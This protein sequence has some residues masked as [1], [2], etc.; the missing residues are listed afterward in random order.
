MAAQI[1]IQD[2]VIELGEEINYNFQVGDL[3]EIS[4]SKSTYTSS[5]KIPRLS[6]FERLFNGLGIAADRSRHPYQIND[7]YLLD[8][9]VPIMKG[10]LVFMRTDE[11][12][13]NVTAISGAFDFFTEIGE[14]KFSDIDISEIVHEKTLDTVYNNIA[15]LFPSNFT[16]AFG[17][18][19]GISHYTDNG[20]PITVNIDA[21][22][23][24]VRAK[25]L[26]NKIFAAFPRFT[27]SGDFYNSTDFGG[28]WV[29]FPYGSLSDIS[30]EV[31]SITLIKEEWDGGAETG[32]ELTGY[33]PWTSIVNGE[34]HFL[35][36]GATWNMRCEDNGVYLFSLVEFNAFVRYPDSGPD[37]ENDFVI[38][39]VS[40]NGVAVSESFRSYNAQQTSDISSFNLEL[41]AGDIVSFTM[42]RNPARNMDLVI[43]NLERLEISVSRRNIDNTLLKNAFGLSIRSFVKEVM[44]RYGLLAFVENNHIDFVRMGSI[45]ESG[46]VVDWSDKYIRRTEEEYTL[47]YHQNNWLRHKYD[48]ENSSYFDKNIQVDNKNINPDKTIIQSDFY[49]PLEN[50]TAYLTYP[51]FSIQAYFFPVF[52]PDLRQVNFP[53]GED[54][55]YKLQERFFFARISNRN[56]PYRIG[57]VM[58]GGVI[59]VPYNPEIHNPVHVI[60]YDN[61]SFEENTYYDP[62]NKILSHTRVHRIDLKLSPIDANQ[63]SLKKRYYFEQEQSFYMLNKLQYKKGDPAKGEYIKISEAINGIWVPIDPYCVTIDGI[64]TGDQGYENL[65]DQLSG[66]VKP[67]VPG[68]PNYVAPSPS[69]SCP[70]EETHPMFRTRSKS[71]YYTFGVESNGTVIK[72]ISHLPDGSIGQI[73]ES[74]ARNKILNLD[75]GQPGA[76][77]IYTAGNLGYMTNITLLGAPSA[78]VEWIDITSYPNIN[79]LDLTGNPI[80]S[81]PNLSSYPIVYLSISG[82]LISSFDSSQVP[83][84][85]VLFIDNT[86]ITSLNNSAIPNVVS[87]NVSSTQIPTM[88][89][90]PNNALTEFRCAGCPFTIDGANPATIDA[91][92]IKMDQNIT[93]GGRLEYGVN[94]TT[95]IQPSSAAAAAYNSLISKGCVIVGRQPA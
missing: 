54:R 42:I 10:V 92:I 73:Y 81:L 91:I 32:N 95:G 51:G 27:F 26:W 33:T 40:V 4:K 28:L 78:G 41:S 22:V 15:G 38:I 52:D 93:S 61:C 25:Y 56:I 11:L 68:D 1:Q 49:S 37:I 62:L 20:G 64:R 9:Y 77:T 80:S 44:W 70:E 55:E 5:F 66:Y 53:S 71:S 46:E 34:I 24:L 84:V 14:T 39:R 21:M 31:L 89:I 69:P 86:P 43:V 13:F 65:R 87:L 36:I 72:I 75:S 82:T 2:T 18:F 12:Y 29:T 35:N 63:L 59:D 57:S 74:A 48:E 6:E 3:G 19:G 7:V 76:S 45:I 67:N 58:Y 88:N 47:D 16:Y 17:Y 79:T 8:D 30:N 90:S 94:N 85:Q 50:L 83:N 23:P 60:T